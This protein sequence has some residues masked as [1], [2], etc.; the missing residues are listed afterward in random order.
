MEMERWSGE[1]HDPEIGGSVDLADGGFEVIDWC[2]HNI[3]SGVMV[4]LE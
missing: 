4:G 2:V 1:A 3:G